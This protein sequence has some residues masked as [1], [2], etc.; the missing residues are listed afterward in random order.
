MKLPRALSFSDSCRR[1]KKSV[2]FSS[3][4]SDPASPEINNEQRSFCFAQLDS[5]SEVCLFDGFIL[6][7][8]SVLEMP[9]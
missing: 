6:E 8:F 4:P 5:V 2:R 9:K 1:R 3:P 7:L